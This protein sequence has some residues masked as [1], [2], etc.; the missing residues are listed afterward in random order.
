MSI[1]DFEDD[2]DEQSDEEVQDIRTLVK[3]HGVGGPAPR[4]RKGIPE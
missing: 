4:K 2:G 1:S 3:D